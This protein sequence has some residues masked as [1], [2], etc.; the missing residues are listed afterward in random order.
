[1]LAI[2]VVVALIG[3]PANAHAYVDDVEVRVDARHVRTRLDARC[4]VPRAQAHSCECRAIYRIAA[5]HA[6][7]VKWPI[8][9]GHRLTLDYSCDRNGAPMAG[10]ESRPWADARG[11]GL[12]AIHVPLSDMVQ[13]GSRRWEIDNAAGRYA[14]PAARYRP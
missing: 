5:V 2:A 13:A 7:P 1:M 14:P 8:D 3:V 4:A 11:N 6:A 10:V 9:P 12:V